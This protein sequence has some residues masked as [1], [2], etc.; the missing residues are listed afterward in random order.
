MTSI[1]IVTYLAVIAMSLRTLVLVYSR[2]RVA[3]QLSRSLRLVLVSESREEF[4][5][6]CGLPAWPGED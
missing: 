2:E 1:A 3:R 6:S 5:A 4:A